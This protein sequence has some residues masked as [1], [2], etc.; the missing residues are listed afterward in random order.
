MH[1]RART[2]THAQGARRVTL[3]VNVWLNHKPE[4]AIP[5][6]PPVCAQLMQALRCPAH[7]ATPSGALPTGH[8]HESPIRPNACVH[9]R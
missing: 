9:P 1:A 3:L 2:R 5:L 8:A 4:Y 6:P 7:R